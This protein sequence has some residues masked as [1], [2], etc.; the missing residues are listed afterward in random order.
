MDRPPGRLEPIPPAQ[1][2]LLALAIVLLAVLVGSAS[3][4]GLAGPAT[5]PSS[6]ATALALLRA[7]VILLGM[8]EAAVVAL[9]AWA[10][11]PGSRGNRRW[12]ARK[13][14]WFLIVASYLQSAVILVGLW[15]YLHFRTFRKAGG[16]AS[17]SGIAFRPPAIVLPDSSA[18]AASGQEWLTAAVV[19]VVLLVAL[20]IAARVFV[21]RRDHRRSPAARLALQLREA[22]DEGLEELEAEPDP[23]LAVIAAYAR[24]ERSLARAGL[25]RLQQETG[26]EYLGRFFAALRLEGPAPAALTDLFLLAK[27]SEHE[28]DQGMKRAAIDA[29]KAIRAD[30]AAIVDE[31]P[32]QA[33]PA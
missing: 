2:G 28:I 31:A 15:L 3:R 4:P 1:L 5:P 13:Q 19:G 18:P 6:P 21:F 11:W 26:L 14:R 24:M 33:V 17:L 16:G 7:G 30:L 9:A 8:L 20:A 12:P 29:L 27:F 32:A 23:R 22:L 10:L 25:P